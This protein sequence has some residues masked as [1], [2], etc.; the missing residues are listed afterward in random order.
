[1]KKQLEQGAQYCVR[2]VYGTLL[3][4]HHIMVL[5]CQDMSYMYV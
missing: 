3:Y 1:M 5:V 2:I 4:T